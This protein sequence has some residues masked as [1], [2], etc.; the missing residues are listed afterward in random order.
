M[1]FTGVQRLDEDLTA[2]AS[3]LR[4]LP[5]KLTLPPDKPIELDTLKELIPAFDTTAMLFSDE[6]YPAIRGLAGPEQG[7]NLDDLRGQLREKLADVFGNPKVSEILSS[8]VEEM[9]SEAKE[10]ETKLKVPD[11]VSATPLLRIVGTGKLRPSLRVFISGDNSPIADMTVDW[12][13]LAFLIR[14]LSSILANN[15]EACEPFLESDAIVMFESERKMIQQRLDQAIEK[16]TKARDGIAKR[17][18]Q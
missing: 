4:D 6:F 17:H 15:L 13:D 1:N 10:E 14:G 7:A 5:A 16:C 3:F 12:D 8:R 11:L 18:G 2:L 9:S